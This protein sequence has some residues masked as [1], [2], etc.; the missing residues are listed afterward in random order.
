M[1]IFAAIFAGF[2]GTA[3]M[4]MLM[5]MAPKMG[6]PEMD[7]MGMLGSMFTQDAGRAK[8]IGAVIHFMMGA[9]F[10]IAYALAWSFGL[11]SVSALWGLIFGAVHGL[12]A[13]VT[14]PMMTRMMQPATA[15][16]SSES[17]TGGGSMMMGM[18]MGHIV[19]GVV[20]ALVYGALL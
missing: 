10:A 8:A 1:N 9:V 19:F 15:G 18:M 5:I 6:M 14:M 3:A 2:T 13:G 4:T 7:V 12:V 16:A 20:V 17:S 11:G